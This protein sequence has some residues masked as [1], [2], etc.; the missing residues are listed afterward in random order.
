VFLKNNNND[1]KRNFK[2]FVLSQPTSAAKTNIHGTH[3]D[4]APNAAYVW[5]LSQKWSTLPS[6]CFKPVAYALPPA[7]FN[8]D[9]GDIFI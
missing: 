8:G 6:L 1:N 4:S 7:F 5:Y 3:Q 2:R 9:R